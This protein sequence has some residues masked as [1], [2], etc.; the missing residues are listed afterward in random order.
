MQIE[1][2]EGLIDEAQMSKINSNGEKMREMMS[3]EIERIKASK[4]Q[5][6]EELKEKVRQ[7]EENL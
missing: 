5:I 6:I 2:K 7:L 3:K 1:E 4:D